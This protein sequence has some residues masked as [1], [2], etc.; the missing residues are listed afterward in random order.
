VADDFSTYVTNEQ[1]IQRARQNLPQGPWDY[2]AGASESETTQRRNRLA[3]DK[4]AFRPRVLV[5]VSEVDASTN[6][7][8]QDIRIPVLLAPIGSLQTFNP[9]GGAEVSEAAGNFGTMHVL[10]SVTLPS[11][12]ET[13]AS[14]DFA[15]S[16]Q[17]YV[18]G[19]WDWTKDMIARVKS[20]GYKGF[21]ITVDTANY[22]RRE[23]PLLSGWNPRSRRDMGGYNWASAVTWDTV[24]KIKAEAGLPFMLKGIATAEDAAIAIEHGVNVI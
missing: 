23:R 7:I 20:A 19:D 1:F 13:M 11:L 21:C 24:D 3:F 5:D 2:L 9:G 6:F 15:K 22:S 14:S 10:S 16:Y 4:I 12:E 17:L 8:G 18:H